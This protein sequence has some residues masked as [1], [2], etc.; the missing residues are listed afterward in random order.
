MN[1]LYLNLV[2]QDNYIVFIAK[3]NKI[4]SSKKRKKTRKEA[5]QI[6]GDIDNI[7]NKSN[8]KKEDINGISVLQGNGS[9]TS[10]RIAAVTANTFAY[11]LKIPAISFNIKGYKGSF[12]NNIWIDKTLEK[13]AKMGK[14]SSY[15]VP[16]YATEPNIT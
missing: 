13:L 6:I 16:E 5:Q 7:I 12:D 15:I 4:I 2:E 3:N 8:I 9:F 14:K 1:I 11:C 10:L